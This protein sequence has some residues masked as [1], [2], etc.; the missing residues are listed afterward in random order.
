VLKENKYKGFKLEV[1]SKI[2]QQLLS[3]LTL[4]K[5]LKII[6]SDLKLENILVNRCL[7][8]IKLIDFGSAAFTTSKVIIVY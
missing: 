3:A 8:Q 2:I 4:L 7:P 1:V 6:H 5:R